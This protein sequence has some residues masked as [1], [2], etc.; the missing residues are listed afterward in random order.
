LNAYLGLV[1]PPQGILRVQ[2][3]LKHVQRGVGTQYPFIQ[4]LSIKDDNINLWQLKLANFDE[5]IEGGRQLNGDLDKL[6]QQ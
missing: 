5:D 6:Q 4:E 2:A 1:H 3:E